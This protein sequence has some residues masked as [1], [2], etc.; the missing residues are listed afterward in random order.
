MNEQGSWLK[1]GVEAIERVVKT[2]VSVTPSIVDV[3]KEKPGTYAVVMPQAP[4]GNASDAIALRTAGP[5]W[6]NEKL[7]SPGELKS[8]IADLEGEM[9]GKVV[10]VSA[11]KITFCYDRDDRRDRATVDMVKSDQWKLL[12]ALSE[13]PKLYT[14]KEVIRLLRIN[15]AGCLDAGTTLINLFRNV[16]FNAGSVADVQVNRG[17]EALSKNVIAQITGISEFPDDFVLSVKVFDN[18]DFKVRLLVAIELHP[19]EG[20]FELVP[21]PNELEKALTETL[22]Q[23]QLLLKDEAPTYLGDPGPGVK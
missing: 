12:E 4:G 1:D 13:S 16:K 6:H 20:R 11:Q 5:L 18:F 21:Y 23:I 7:D 9:T 14:Q 15:F 3:P 19:S 2:A 10:Y 22:S 8:F 17:N